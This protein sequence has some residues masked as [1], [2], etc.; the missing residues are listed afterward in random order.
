M[1]NKLKRLFSGHNVMLLIFVLSSSVSMAEEFHFKFTLKDK[2]WN[3]SVRSDSKN[4]AFELASQ[5]CL[6][7]FTGAKKDQKI[8]VDEET[9]DS[10]LNTCANPKI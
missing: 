7:H 2:T 1:T 5:E 9:A 8:K 10:L 4:S 6:N 3:Y